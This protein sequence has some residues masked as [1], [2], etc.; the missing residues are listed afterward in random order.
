MFALGG[1]RE[2]G[3]D[4]QWGEGVEQQ[5]ADALVE[6]MAA[7][8]GADRPGVVDPV[9]LAEVGGQVLA[10]AL[11]VAHGHP[12]PAA[13]ADDDPLQQGGAFAGR[14]GGAVEAV[15]GGVGGQAGAVDVVLVQGDVSG[16]DVGD[17]G[18][19]LFA[20]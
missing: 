19:P 7:D 15:R 3:L 14:A 13:T 12:P 8:R 18:D 16:V 5:L 1:D 11:V 10:G 20:G 9:A 6:L 2:R 4:G 17:E